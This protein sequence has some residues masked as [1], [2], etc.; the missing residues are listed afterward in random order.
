MTRLL[1]RGDRVRLIRDPSQDAVDHYGRL[2]RYVEHSGIDVGRKQILRGH[3]RV[4]VY[5]DNAFRRVS[6]YRQAQREAKHNDR[7]A[8]GDCGRHF[9]FSRIHG[10]DT[11][12]PQ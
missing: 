9:R 4:Y 6:S 7:G 3:A 2:L 8:W 1:D 11:V 10:N 12:E 5:D